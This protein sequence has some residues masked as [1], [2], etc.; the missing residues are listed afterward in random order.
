MDEL[1]N[2]YFNLVLWVFSVFDLGDFG[3]FCEV[4]VSAVCLR[5]QKDEEC[6]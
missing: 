1:D 5:C 3:A 2:M 4:A 6:L